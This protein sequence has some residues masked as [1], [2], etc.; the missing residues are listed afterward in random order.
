MPIDLSTFVAPTSYAP[1]PGQIKAPTVSYGTNNF[2]PPVMDSADL[3]RILSLPRRAL[4]LDGTPRAEAI[5]DSIGDMYSRRNTLC[6]CRQIDA[7]RHAAEGCIDRARLVQAI[8]LREIAI[9]GGLLGPIGVGH[10]K[11]FLDLLAALAFDRHAQHVG[12]PHGPNLLC[13][14]FVPPKLI[15]QLAA[16]YD[17]IGEHWI[18]PS[19]VVQGSPEFDRIRP[20]MPKLQVMP[21]SRLQLA[22]S[23][24]WLK[25][26]KPHA[27]IADECHKLRNIPRNGKRGSSTATRVDAFM[28]DSPHTLFAGWSGSMTKSSLRDYDRLAKWALRGGSPLPLDDDAL[29]DWCRSIDAGP[30]PADP[31]ALMDGLIATGFCKP[32]ESVRTGLRRRIHET[33]GVVTASAP[34]VD[35]ELELVEREITTE[36]PDEIDRLIDEALDFIRPDG[37]ELVTAMQ[38]V[39]CA[40]QI[41]H[42]FHYKWIY[43]HNKF[44]EDNELVDT[45]RLRRKDWHKELR[46]MLLHPNEQMDSPKLLQNA[47]ERFYGHRTKV[48]GQPVWESQTYPAWREIKDKVTPESVA[49]RLDDFFVR[50]VVAWAKEHAGIVWYWHSAFGE[51]VA[52]ESGLPLYGAGKEAAR[53]MLTYET[54]KSSI[55]VSAKAHGTG[56]NG[57]QFKFWDQY[58]TSTPSDPTAWEQ[59]LGRLHRPGQTSN[60]VR[61]WFPMHTEE[62]RKHTKAALR[63]ALYV[64]ETGFGDQKLRVGF[65]LDLLAEL[66]KDEEE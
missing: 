46:S 44:P 11:T 41:A 27:I 14:L 45:W 13:V 63:A 26:V 60:I 48:K 38:A 23:A 6:R 20:G 31:G 18:M 25:V 7:E 56:T 55:I 9:V 36:I 22:E 43:P 65:P 53:Q 33:L 66:D 51:W 16:D 5:I 47:A 24:S 35:I 34:S 17:Y 62:L 8:A 52:E 40:I 64:G 42:G 3:Q 57:L 58:F 4:E 32:G 19:M 54:G 10:G 49:V 1:L 15:P 29:D 39:E 61:A 28:R 37:E 12:L 59:T 2:R 21:Y 30:N 50:D